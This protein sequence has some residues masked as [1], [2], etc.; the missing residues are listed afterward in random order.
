MIP[1]IGGRKLSQI[2]DNLDINFN[3]PAEQIEKL[4]QVSSIELG[5]P[6]DFFNQEMP[7]QFVYGGLFDSIDN[8]RFSQVG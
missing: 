2:K 4:N 6:H 3:L 5:F 8:H 1:I 7:R